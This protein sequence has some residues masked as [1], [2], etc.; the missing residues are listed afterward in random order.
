MGW[1]NVQNTIKEPWNYVAEGKIDLEEQKRAYESFVEAWKEVTTDECMG[2][3]V[4]EWIPGVDGATR[5]GT[6]SLQ[7][8]PALEV[9]KGWWKGASW[10]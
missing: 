3:F 7:N 8:T 2:A 1:H 5:H 9:V 4:W 6:Y 10:K